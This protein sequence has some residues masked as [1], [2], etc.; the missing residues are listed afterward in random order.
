MWPNSYGGHD[1]HWMI[2]G[3]IGFCW[4]GWQM[5]EVM[6][7]MKMTLNDIKLAKEADKINGK[8]RLRQ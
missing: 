5:W 7:Q 3:V 6:R 4:L 1:W 2:I 8:V